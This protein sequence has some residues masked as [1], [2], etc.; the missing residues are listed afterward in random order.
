MD[1][2]SVTTFLTHPPYRMVV[3]NIVSISIAL[4]VTFLYLSKT[5][6]K[7]RNYLFLVLLFSIPPIISILRQGTYESGDLSINAIKLMSFVNSLSDG[8]FIPR[9]SENL[10]A[11]YGY[12]NFIF[13]YPLPYY[14]GSLFKYLGFSF[15]NSIKLILITSYLI[16]GVAMY[17][18]L[19]HFTPPF[20]ALMGAL[21]YQYAPYHFVDMHFRVNIGEMLALMFLPLSFYFIHLA[22]T[23]SSFL[24]RFGA[25]ASLGLLILSHQAV[26]LITLPLVFAYS[27]LF[28]KSNI[29]SKVNKIFPIFFITL[30]IS[31]YYWIPA[32]VEGKYTHQLYE[33]QNIIPFYNL[34]DYLFSPYRFGFLF[35][36]PYGELSPVIGY[37]HLIFVILAIY[38]IIKKK[39]KKLLM[40]FLISFFIYFFLMQKQSNPI[41]QMFSV[42]RKIQF[43]YRMLSIIIFIT[44][45]LAS[46]VSHL[47]NKKVLSFILLLLAIT[48]SILN[49]GNRRVLPDINDKVLRASLP[50]SSSQGEGLGPALPIWIPKDVRF[51]KE[52]PPSHLEPLLGKVSII[53]QTRNSTMHYYLV[54]TKDGGILKE[55]TY[56][57]PGWKLWIDGAQKNINYTHPDYPGIITFPIDKG[58]HT[59]ILK[60][61]N[62]PIRNISML[63]TIFSLTA[64]GIYS[65]SRSLLPT[66]SSPSSKSPTRKSSPS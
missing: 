29:K 60:F 32:L 21:L 8:H 65:I 28:S 36:G 15:I 62:T 64:I 56:Y 38:L 55:N 66:P 58:R 33:I 2:I 4:V 53:S 7:K 3:V 6:L 48:A 24:Y 31:A 9:W 61:V 54:E 57:F 1:L 47:L 30:S 13:A 19:R 46:I 5:P 42:L 25:S 50:L 63:I 51:Q 23:K 12:P 40:F 59:I 22:I 16:S 27:F 49:W 20:H 44:S 34:R 39:K 26:S 18:W 14:L 41:W 17:K 43:P 52:I 10:N 35:Q 37:S 11:T 45:S